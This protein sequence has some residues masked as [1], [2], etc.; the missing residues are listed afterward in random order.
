MDLN[1]I[2]L[3][4][5]EVIKK[6]GEF[7]RGEFEKV[8][9]SDIKVK[10]LNSLV[11]YIDTTAEEMLVT[12]LKPLIPNTG[13]LTEEETVEQSKAD[14]RWIIDPLDGTTNFIH[15]LPCFAVSVA[16][17]FKGEIILGVVYDVPHNKCYH[18]IQ[19]EKAY[20]DQ[21]QIQVSP[22]NLLSESLIATGFPYYDY[23]R[24]PQYL[25]VLETLIKSTRGVRRFGSAAMDLAWVACGKFD[26]FYEYS[27]S[28]WDVAA[29]A[30]IVQQAG[31]KVTDFKG[32][33]N[34]LY[35][36]EII[37]GNKPVAD[38]VLGVCM[39]AFR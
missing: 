22:N 15:G 31:G 36:Q 27:L 7:I 26:V 38:E 14:Y 37:A 28:P 9:N 12:G 30:F 18:A 25:K 6:T 11:T 8:T 17:E 39:D 16:L 4:A 35:G 2:E 10:A 29:G 13:F 5:I 3:Q 19:N 33:D 1:K 23:D 20:C 21:T 32:G 34:W 24:T